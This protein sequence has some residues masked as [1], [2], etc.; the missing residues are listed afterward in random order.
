L[1]S[2]AASKMSTG[3]G[4]ILAKL[5][6]QASGEAIEEFLSYVGN[7]I[8]DNALIDKLGD[9]DFSSKWD[10]GEVG[11]QM[12]LAFVSSAISLGGES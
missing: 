1:A 4:K 12:A 9:S 6:V 10:W 11:E 5:G 7:Y 2:K 8:V 3:A